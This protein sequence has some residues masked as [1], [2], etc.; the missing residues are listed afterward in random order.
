MGA[1]RAQRGLAPTDSRAGGEL[2]VN[3]G[4]K[5]LLCY[6]KSGW[7][8][9]G[10]LRLA[11]LHGGHQGA[12]ADLDRPQIADVVDFE[13]GVEPSCTTCMSGWVHT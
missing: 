11:G 12:D 2:A 4:I 1:P 8:A 7:S 6:K 9:P 10:I 5:L 3:D 13:L